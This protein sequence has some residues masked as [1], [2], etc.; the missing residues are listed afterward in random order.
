MVFDGSGSTDPD[1]TIVAYDWIFDDGTFASGVKV[2]HTFNYSSGNRWVTLRL[3]DDKGG[4][5]NSTS[6]FSFSSSTGFTGAKDEG[7]V[8]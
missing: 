4:Q 3:T 7:I 6:Y 1:G 8:T 2:K 5:K